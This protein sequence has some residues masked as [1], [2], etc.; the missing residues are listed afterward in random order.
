MR[1]PFIAGNWKMNKTIK[2]AVELITGLKRSLVDIEDV[3][4]AV[5]PPFTALS[6]AKEL[7][8]DSNIRLGAQN[9]FWEKEGAYT[10]EI[11]AVMLKEV[12]C[13][14][15]IIG[16]SERRQYFN[17]TNESVNKKIKAALSAGLLP[18]VCVG[19]ILKERE[20]NKTF[21]VVKNHVEKA[22][23]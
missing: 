1:K 15:V 22:L 18:I 20:S 23:T 9:L 10:G 4:I 16:H 17:E 21:D 19:E 7:L 5:C 13:E 11:S 8:I 14:F 3:D 2:E 12:G 6:D